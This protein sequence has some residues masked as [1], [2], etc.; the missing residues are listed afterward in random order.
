MLAGGG[1]AGGIGAALVAF[2][3]ARLRPGAE[4][5]AASLKLEELIAGADLVITGEGRLD[6]QSVRG[7]APLAVAAIAKRHSKPVIALAGSLGAGHEK[8]YGHGVGAMFSVV[9]R[10]CTVE[11][12]LS[13]AKGNVIAAARNV[14]LALKMG[15]NLQLSRSEPDI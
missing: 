11:E 15:M 9:S 10:V 4:I 7:K 2:L 13:E 8:A 5:I 1:A 6:G 12:A 14:A 3:G